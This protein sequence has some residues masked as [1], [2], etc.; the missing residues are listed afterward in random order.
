MKEFGKGGSVMYLFIINPSAGNG[1]ARM[2]WDETEK[3][4]KQYKIAYK[5]LMSHSE[6]AARKF[7]Q[8]NIQTQSVTSIGVVGGDGTVSSV[9]QQVA[10]TSISLAILPAGSG[11]DT[12]RMFRLTSD[13]GIFVKGLIK[14]QL[15]TIDLLK[16]KERFGITIAGAGIDAVI[17]RRVD[18]SIY[19]P[20]FNK[21]GIGSFAYTIAAIMTVLSFKPFTSTVT[22]DG[23][24]YSMEKTWLA[25]VGNTTSYGGGLV[26]CPQALPSDGTLNITLLRDT[27]RLTVLLRL[28]PALLRGGPILHKGISYKTGKHIHIETNRPISVVMDGEIIQ[29]TPLEINV[30]ERALKLIAT[31]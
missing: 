7:I 9:I 29:T 17:G 30:C 26:V 16:A 24:A 12:A 5:A 4:L 11:N 28:F 1:Q 23:V 13:P 10:G 2:L 3:K 21:L 31:T 8:E 27:K 14:N 15:T 18:R 25:A 20:L 19:K 22:I 6:I